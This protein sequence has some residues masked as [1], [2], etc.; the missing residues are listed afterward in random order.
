MVT[1]RC[2]FQEFKLVPIETTTMALLFHLAECAIRYG[3]QVHDFC[4]MSNH[5]HLVLT[6]PQGRLPD[7]MRDFNSAVARVLNYVAGA[8]ENVFS[9]ESGLDPVWWTPPERTRYRR[10][11]R[12][13]EGNEGRT[14][15]SN[16]PRRSSWWSRVDAA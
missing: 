2:P 12:C 1:V 6:D 5:Y 13:Q 11:R 9:T 14:R 3:I 8:R 7:F 15:P 10:N 4:F 16:E